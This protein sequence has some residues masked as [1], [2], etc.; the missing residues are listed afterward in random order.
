MLLI[1]S[2]NFSL[3]RHI[4]WQADGFGLLWCTSASTFQPANHHFIRTLTGS[5][6]TCKLIIQRYL[7]NREISCS[8]FSAGSLTIL[9]KETSSGTRTT[10]EP[11]VKTS[12]Q[13]FDWSHFE[14]TVFITRSKEPF[15]T[16]GFI[17]KVTIH[18]FRQG[19]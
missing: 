15:F 2:M 8:S 18:Q 14:D 17:Q 5:V 1:G 4:S 13:S 11:T 7:R 19:F 9:T 10:M 16:F 6:N 12:T 3:V